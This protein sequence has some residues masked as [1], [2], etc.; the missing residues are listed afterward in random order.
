MEEVNALVQQGW[1]FALCHGGGPQASQLQQRLGMTPTKVGGRRITDA[2]T[3]RVMKQV[4]AGEVN[5]DVVAAATAAGLVPVG[6]SGVSAVAMAKCRR[7]RMPD[8]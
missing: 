6:I 8:E 1:L 5:V 3:L 7:A 2:P 4:L